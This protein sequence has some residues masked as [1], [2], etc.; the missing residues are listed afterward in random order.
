MWHPARY[1][2]DGKVKYDERKTIPTFIHFPVL[3][4][5][6]LGKRLRVGVAPSNAVEHAAT[7]LEGGVLGVD[8]S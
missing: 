8:E 3:D 5:P 4:S 1:L 6:S 7:E 2:N